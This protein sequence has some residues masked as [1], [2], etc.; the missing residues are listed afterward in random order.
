MARLIKITIIVFCLF[1]C[2]IDADAAFNLGKNGPKVRGFIESG[3]GVKLGSDNTK[4][5]SFN[6]FEQRLQLKTTAYP[7][8]TQFL[9]DWMA[10]FS[11]KGDFTVDEY[12][13]GKTDF[14]LRESNLAL[15]PAK[16]I[17]LKIGR[18]VFTWGTGDY[19][20]V[21]DLFP[22]DYV[23]FYIGR[24]DE[25]LKKPSDGAKV[26]LYSKKVNLD[27]IFI[28][29]FEANTIFNGER[30]SFFDSFQ[31]GI[32]GRNS[33]R[34][35]IE[36]SRQFNNAEF[37]ARAYRNFGSL[38][39]ALYN[40]RGFYKMPRGYLNEANRELFYPRLDAYGMSLRW[41][42]LGGIVNFES[43]F[44][45]SRQDRNG[46]NRLIENSMMKYLAGYSKDLGGN[47]LVGVQYMYENMF[48]YGNYRNALLEGDSRWDEHRHLFTLRIL[49]MFRNQTVKSGLFTFF[50]PSDMDVYI[51]PSL[52]YELN[53]NWGV[54][55]G[56]NLVWGRDNH[57]E[58][59]QMEN[60]KNV[61]FRLRYSF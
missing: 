35:I 21:N 45:N 4:R 24:E 11:F 58:F 13:D 40:F 46:D 22:K 25:Y 41:P 23:S 18:E 31:G 15:S 1:V 33:D 28:P 48:D 39:T 55:L 30:L 57:T 26:S 5:D 47:C 36:P 3:F 44:Y 12:F 38:E 53:D 60:N 59:G 51:R 54:N 32:A 2:L 14:E 27:L 52:N 16:W 49:K 19:L 56:A 17:D 9:S 6:F 29:L 8:F 43:A 61:Y 10:E 7:E 37:A 34:K 20:F 50:S 42:A